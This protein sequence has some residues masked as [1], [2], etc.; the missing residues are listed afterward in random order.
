MPRDMIVILVQFLVI[1][2]AKKLIEPS[3]CFRCLVRVKARE[4]QQTPRSGVP[5]TAE[6]CLEQPVN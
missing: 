5:R 1:E 2:A 4:Q 6:N 3:N